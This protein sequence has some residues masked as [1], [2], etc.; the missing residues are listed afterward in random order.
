VYRYKDYHGKFV[1]L[2]AD[3]NFFLRLLRSVSFRL[4]KYGLRKLEKTGYTIVLQK[5]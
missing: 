2:N 5:E 4:R 3:T 1:Y